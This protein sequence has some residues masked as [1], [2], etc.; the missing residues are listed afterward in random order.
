MLPAAPEAMN[1]NTQT[2]VVVL[3]EESVV[4]SN[5]NTTHKGRVSYTTDGTHLATI[6]DYPCVKVYHK[7]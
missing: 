2:L 4:N 1:S 3:C 6:V 5:G 7:T